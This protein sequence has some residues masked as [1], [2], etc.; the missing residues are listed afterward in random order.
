MS[1]KKDKGNPDIFVA[2]KYHAVFNKKG[3]DNI[4][5]MCR[6]A[7]I[8]CVVCKNEL[9]ASINKIL[10][11]IRARRKHYEKR[12]DDVGDILQT[13]SEKM[14]KIGKAT[15]DEVKEAMSIKYF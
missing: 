14:V 3:C 11:P 8:G 13:G 10:E 6:N 4:G 7:G 9:S 15:V 12:I 1:E 2:Y 5:E